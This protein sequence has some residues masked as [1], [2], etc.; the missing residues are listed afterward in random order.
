MSLAKDI[1]DSVALMKERCNGI[2]KNKARINSA[3]LKE[4]Y[5]TFLREF[6]QYS[7]RGPET[8]F[9]IEK[10]V[11]ALNELSAHRASVVTDPS[12]LPHELYI[13]IRDTLTSIFLKWRTNVKSVNEQELNI[14]SNTVSL[15]NNMVKTTLTEAQ[16]QLF[17]VWLL[18]KS[19][20]ELFMNCIKDM[21]L[22]TVRSKEKFNDNFILLVS[23]LGYFQQSRDDIMDDLNLLMLSA[24]ILKMYSVHFSSMFMQAVD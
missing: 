24:A 15:L 21:T 20:L 8:L 4:L 22:A 17:K 23:L 9:L 19:F 11:V 6:A 13:N 3:W 7:T 18:E 14:M 12:I 10:V 16:Y 5:N 1:R 2:V